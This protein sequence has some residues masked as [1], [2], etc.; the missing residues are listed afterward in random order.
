MKIGESE[1]SY[2][3]SEQVIFTVFSFSYHICLKH[4]WAFKLLILSLDRIAVLGLKITPC[5]KAFYTAHTE[6]RKNV[7]VNCISFNCEV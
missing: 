6:E 3:S 2:S 4:L 7:P 5:Y 1:S